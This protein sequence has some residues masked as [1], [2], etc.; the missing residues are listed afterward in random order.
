MESLQIL[1]QYLDPSYLNLLAILN[2]LHEEE[3]IVGINFANHT[4]KTLKHK[5]K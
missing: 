1:G 2:L 3:V 4:F 5:C